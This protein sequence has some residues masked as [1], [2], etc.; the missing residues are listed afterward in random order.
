MIRF[1]SVDFELIKREIIW[2]DLIC[3]GE[4]LKGTENFLNSERLKYE[5]AYGTPE[6]S[7]YKLRATPGQ[8]QGRKRKLNPATARK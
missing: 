5:Q 7:I 1:L 3:S 6:G 8:Q 4:P 2:V